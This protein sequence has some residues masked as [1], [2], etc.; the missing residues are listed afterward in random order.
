[1]ELRLGQEVTAV[2]APGVIRVMSYNVRIAPY[3]EDDDT[4]NA[5]SYRLPKIALLLEYYKPDIV[6]F[7]EVSALQIKGLA[8][9]GYSKPYDFLVSGVSGGDDGQIHLAIMYNTAVCEPIAPLAVH[10]FT[11]TGKIG[12]DY[13][14]SGQERCVIY[15]QFKSKATGLL[16]FFMTTH[17]DHGGPNARAQSAADLIK[18]AASFDAP[19][20]I[21]GDFNC[22]PQAGG[23]ELYDFLTFSCPAV[24]DSALLAECRVGVAGSW[25]GWDYDQ[26]RDRTATYHYDHILIS[27]NACVFQ[28]GVLDD[29]VWDEA[30]GCEL[31][32]SDHRPVIADISWPGV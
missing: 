32:P 31:Y 28:Y 29:R 10:W 1:M 30:F 22:F 27:K 2:S 13:D 24:T 17:F 16:W 7:Q 5:W 15:A 9:C 4:T 19:V 8:R 12:A 23:K 26:Y 14:G 11:K 18:L 6:G 25:M 21:T 3:A 20:V